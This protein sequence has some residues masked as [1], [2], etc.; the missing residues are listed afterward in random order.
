[1]WLCGTPKESLVIPYN[2]CGVLEY[3]AL[4]CTSVYEKDLRL[5]LAERAHRFSEMSASINETKEGHVIITI[6]EEC[7][8]ALVEFRGWHN[9]SDSKVRALSHML[10]NMGDEEHLYITSTVAPISA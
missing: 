9:I 5:W 6:I 8:V 3:V 2:M 1:M 4:A 10:K 7:K